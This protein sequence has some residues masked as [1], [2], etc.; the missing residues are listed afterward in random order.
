MMK[1]QIVKQVV[2]SL[3]RASNVGIKD[4][5][6]PDSL[7]TDLSIDLPLEISVMVRPK[8]K[9]IPDLREYEEGY[10][11]RYI[12]WVLTHDPQ[13]PF[14]SESMLKA[15]YDIEVFS[16]RIAE[17]DLEYHHYRQQRSQRYRAEIESLQTDRL[18]L[19]TTG[20][21]KHEAQQLMATA[22]TAKKAEITTQYEE[23]LAALDREYTIIKQQCEERI[24]QACKYLN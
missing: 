5:Q 15:N 17:L 7:D 22:R 18:D 24:N 1:R 19:D 9:L 16:Q 4:S 6:P 12:T 23:D 14:K 3:I 21:P 20:R 10:I 2:R 8:L 13:T 11:D